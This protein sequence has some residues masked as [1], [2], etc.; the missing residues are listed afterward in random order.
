M[1]DTTSKQDHIKSEPRKCWV[2]V[3]RCHQ[4]WSCKMPQSPWILLLSQ[5]ELSCT[6]TR[7][8]LPQSLWEE[9]LPPW[10]LPVKASTPPYLTQNKLS[11]C[12]TPSSFHCNTWSIQAPEAVSLFLQSCHIPVQ[13][14]PALR[15]SLWR[16]R[17]LGLPVPETELEG[18]WDS[19]ALTNGHGLFCNQIVFPS[20]CFPQGGTQMGLLE[21]M[22]IYKGTLGGT[23][24]GIKT[25]L[26]QIISGASISLMQREQE[27]LYYSVQDAGFH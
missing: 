7:P 17:W 6:S 14:W 8:L 20:L 9:H 2:L 22:A 10:T 13:F 5:T 21:E 24:C 15:P 4:G 12:H 19:L 3:L 27:W 1:A 11:S 26:Q 25:L 23:R 16:E 18:T